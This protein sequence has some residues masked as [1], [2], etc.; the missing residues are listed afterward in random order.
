MWH[1]GDNWN[2]HHKATA[3]I[4]IPTT[5]TRAIMTIIQPANPPPLPHYNLVCIWN[6]Y[7]HPRSNTFPLDLRNPGTTNMIHHCSF[8]H[9]HQ[10]NLY[11]YHN[12]LHPVRSGGILGRKAHQYNCLD[13]HGQSTC[14][15]SCSNSTVGKDSRYQYRTLPLLF[16]KARRTERQTQHKLLS[17]LYTP[18]FSAKFLWWSNLLLFTGMIFVVRV[19]LLPCLSRHAARIT[20]PAAL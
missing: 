9:R 1:N 17:S 4:G 20:Y 10:Q 16:E 19:P 8:L 18:S 2:T 6:Q 12:K 3:I 14:Q 13:T 15:N 11:H 5:T 7:R